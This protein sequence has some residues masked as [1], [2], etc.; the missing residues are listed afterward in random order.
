MAYSRDGDTLVAVADARAVGTP[1]R[2]RPGN[3]MLWVLGT[4]GLGRF[5]QPAGESDSFASA[6]DRDL[7]ADFLRFAADPGGD[8]ASALPFADKVTLGLADELI[9]TRTPSELGHPDAWVLDAEGFRAYVGPFSALDVA[10]HATETVVSVGDHPHCVSPPVPAPTEV[11][12]LRRVSVQPSPASI[13][14]CLQ[15]WTVD[16]FLTDD[17]RI[18]AVTLDLY[19]P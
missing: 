19:E 10:A 8:T 14:S 13:D 1:Y 15:W 2:I 16:L 6:E 17:Q 4:A 12:D 7:I 9:T 3:G 18:A 11:A 5:D